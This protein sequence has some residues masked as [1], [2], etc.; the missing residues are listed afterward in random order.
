MIT[1]KI[2]GQLFII[3]YTK[4]FEIFCRAT[5]LDIAINSH[6]YITMGNYNLYK[7]IGGLN[8]FNSNF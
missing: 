1:Q 7:K 8:C 3:V 6:M 4:N 2:L 5:D